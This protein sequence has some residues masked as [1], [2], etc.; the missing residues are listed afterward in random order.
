MRQL[1]EP[2][3]RLEDNIRIDLKRNKVGGEVY[4]EFWP[5]IMKGIESFED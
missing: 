4:G 2:T 3:H 1:G 5:E